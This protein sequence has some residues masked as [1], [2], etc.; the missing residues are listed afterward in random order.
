MI[1]VIVN[2]LVGSGG[3]HKTKSTTATS[4]AATA[5]T[6]TH[7]THPDGKPITLSSTQPTVAQDKSKDRSLTEIEQSFDLRGQPVDTSVKGSKRQNP[8]ECVASSKE[9]SS[10]HSFVPKSGSDPKMTKFV[11]QES[12][13]M[14]AVNPSN[15]KTDTKFGVS[16]PL[17]VKVVGSKSASSR[18][19]KHK[20]QHLEGSTWGQRSGSEASSTY[21]FNWGHGSTISSPPLNLSGMMSKTSSMGVEVPSED[22]S[23]QA[24]TF[25]PS[26]THTPPSSGSLTTAAENNMM[27]EDLDLKPDIPT[28]VTAAATTGRMFG[29]G[30]QARVAFP[31]GR[32][33]TSQQAKV[34]DS[35]SNGPIWW[36]TRCPI[37]V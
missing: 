30:G 31:P 3:H 32:A 29:V 33:M 5:T 26:S 28:P 20:L 16:K 19:Y 14:P 10:G 34:V 18:S 7:S 8:K 4:T 1:E 23:S 25:P 24:T 17:E 35:M 9:S 27:F 6:K 15:T 2:N 13:T 22:A 36:E 11:D 37:Y 21:E 12:T